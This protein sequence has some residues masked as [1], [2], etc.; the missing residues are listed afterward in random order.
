MPSDRRPDSHRPHRGPWLRADVVVVGAGPAGCAAA[1]DLAR[2]GVRV[3]LLDRTHFPRPKACAGGLTVK[4]VRALRYDIAPVVQRTVHRLAVSCDLRR[5]RILSS[6]D[7]ICS[8]VTR[9][10]FDAYCLERTQNAGARF[11][12]VEHIRSVAE[13]ASSVTLLTERGPIRAD[14]LVAAD[15]A[16]SRIR[17]LTGRFNGIRN[18]FAV[19]G[20]VDRPSSGDP[21]MTFDFG[22]V[23]D[24]Y[25]WVFPKG[26]RINVGLY[27]RRSD[28]PLRRRALIGYAGR[29]LGTS[30]VRRIVGLPL[31]M[32]GWGYRPGRGR[33]LLTGDAAGLVDPLLGEGLYH[34]VISGQLAGRAVAAALAS[35]CD[36]C[37]A[38]AAAI[39]PIQRELYFSHGVAT[40]FYRYPRAGHRLLVSPAARLALMGGFSAGLTMSGTIFRGYRFWLGRRRSE[41][42]GR[43]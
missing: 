9:S 37:R 17:R 26:E 12:V 13:T 15:G 7:P 10:A 27:A 29:R 22:L 19:E 25:G 3:L 21:L 36:A 6:P 16:G 11:A 43:Q 33:V 30:S 20:N 4:T 32:G 18:G 28:F 8:M 40:A 23:Q 41:T 31:G 38:Y 39:R 35:D 42:A 14:F 2:R 1:Y 5:Q 24:G 34:A